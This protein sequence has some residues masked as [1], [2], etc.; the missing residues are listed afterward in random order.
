M[1][2]EKLKEIRNCSAIIYFVS[3]VQLIQYQNRWNDLRKCQC[4]S[5]TDKSPV[6]DSLLSEFG[7]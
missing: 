1:R 4:S 5:H 6:A 7:L 2:M 3:I